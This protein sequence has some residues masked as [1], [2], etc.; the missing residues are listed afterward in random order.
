MSNSTIMPTSHTSKGGQHPGVDVARQ[1]AQTAGDAP[2]PPEAHREVGVEDAG[3]RHVPAHRDIPG[4]EREQRNGQQN[5]RQR[6][7]DRPGQRMHGHHRLGEN[8]HEN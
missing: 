8:R 2:T 5:E 6:Y 3:M 4:G 7:P 1:D